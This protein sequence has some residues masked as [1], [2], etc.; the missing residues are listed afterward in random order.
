MQLFQEQASV[1]AVKAVWDESQ[2]QQDEW[3]LYRLVGNQFGQ[4]TRQ[5]HYK[6]SSHTTDDQGQRV[7]RIDK[8]L[9]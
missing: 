7:S 5:A 8:D 6:D 9:I 1:N 4:E 2:R 3:Y